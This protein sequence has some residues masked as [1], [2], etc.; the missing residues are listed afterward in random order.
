MV[1]PHLVD[2]TAPMDAAI[3]EVD[4]RPSELAN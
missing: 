2:F 1:I 4:V 3:G